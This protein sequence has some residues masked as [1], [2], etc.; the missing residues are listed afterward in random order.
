[1]TFEYKA[2]CFCAV[3]HQQQQLDRCLYGAF[4]LCNHHAHKPM[5]KRIIIKKNE[6]T[7]YKEYTK[8]E[9]AKKERP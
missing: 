5:P 7:N 4:E 3:F 9:G 2:V 8:N 6:E 1:M